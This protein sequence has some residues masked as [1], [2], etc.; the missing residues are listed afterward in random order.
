MKRDKLT[1]AEALNL[2][3]DLKRI[4]NGAKLSFSNEASVSLVMAASNLYTWLRSIGN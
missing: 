1:F 4:S 3:A 2:P